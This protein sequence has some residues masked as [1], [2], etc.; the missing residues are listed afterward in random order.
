MTLRETLSSA[1][2]VTAGALFAL[3]A[4]LDTQAASA[5]EIWS[6]YGNSA[7]RTYFVLAADHSFQIIVPGAI[8]IRRSNNQDCTFQAFDSDG[9]GNVTSQPIYHSGS[10]NDQLTFWNDWDWSEFTCGNSSFLVRSMLET[11]W[12]AKI[13]AGGGDDTVY[14]AWGSGYYY[15]EGGH[16]L[17]LSDRMHWGKSQVFGGTEDDEMWT[18]GDNI[19]F[20]GE[21]GN[22]LLCNPHAKIVPWMSGGSG[23]DMRLGPSENSPTDIEYHNGPCISRPF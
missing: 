11:T 2:R 18:Y 21:W 20:H 15:L 4:L 16:D 23:W 5:N 1:C 22:D 17:F 6:P 10:G 7:V 3:A 14:E 8:S 12:I 19:D 9:Q 13:Y